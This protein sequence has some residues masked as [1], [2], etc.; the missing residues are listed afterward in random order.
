MFFILTFSVG[1]KY[2]IVQEALEDSRVCSELN[3]LN[4]NIVAAKNEISK[5]NFNF[6][7]ISNEISLLRTDIYS[8]LSITNTLI[9]QTKSSMNNT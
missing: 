5:L 7:N 3:T 1:L 2:N 9:N 6:D 8:D 4:K